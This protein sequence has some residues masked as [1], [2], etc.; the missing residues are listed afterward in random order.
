MQIQDNP[1]VVAEAPA[2]A[3]ASFYRKAYGLAALAFCAWA[4]MLALL[5]ASGAY[6]PVCN[7]IFGLGSIGWLLVLAVFWG[8]TALAQSLAFTRGEVGKQYLGLGL[9]AL[10]EALIFTPLIATVAVKTQGDLMQILAPAGV[11]TLALMVALTATVFMT[12]VDF[13]FLKTA[14]V[15]GSF[16][17]LGAIVCFS[18]FSF[19]PGIWFAVAMIA[20]MVAAILWQTWQIKEQCDTDQHVGAAVLIFAGFVTLLWYVI[21][22]F[23]SRR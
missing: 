14:V 3:R 18:I 23:L 16:A 20:L 21:Q 8:A 11:V 10:A 1:F 15:L 7:L 6:V 5:F 13:S 2:Q 17:A 22:L 12:R 19:A 9:Y 4:G